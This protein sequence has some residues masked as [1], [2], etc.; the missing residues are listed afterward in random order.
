M[1]RFLPLVLG[2]ALLS[3]MP[4][5]AAEGG[6]RGA[7]PPLSGEMRKFIAADAPKP[8]PPI[9]F[10]DE[11][12]A[13]I[14]LEAFRGQIVLLN[15]WATWCIPCRQ[16]MPALD[17]LQA[18]IGPDQGFRVVPLAVD[19]AGRA[20]VEAFLT[21]VGVKNLKPY[22][23][24]TMKSA[25]NLGAN[26]LPTTLLL[27]REGRELGRLIGEAVWDSD[28]AIDLIRTILKAPKG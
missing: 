17:R 27:D 2:L 18:R 4:A 12:D 3:A 1:S 13:E 16:E 23:D 8:V 26:G 7:L 14:G 10:R 15:L 28:E 9:A 22:L 6:K 24:V 20:K 5:Q 11:K 19:R 21:E 25:R